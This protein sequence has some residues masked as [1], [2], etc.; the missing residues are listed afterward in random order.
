MSNR[1]D[2]LFV[3]SARRSQKA[4]TPAI[5]DSYAVARRRFKNGA[6][7]PAYGA[8]QNA[9][10]E[11]A[12]LAMAQPMLQ[13]VASNSQYAAANTAQGQNITFDLQNVGLNTKIIIEVSGTLAATAGQNLV[14][15][16]FG[17]LNFLSNVQ[18]TDLSNYQ[19]VNTTGRHLH[20]LACIRRQLAFGAAYQN[21]S[22][23][24][25]GST[26]NVQNAEQNIDEA[27]TTFRIFYE[28]P[29]AYGEF[30]L[31]GAIY[32]SVVNA[33]WRLQVTVNPSLTVATGGTD[34]LNPAYIS[35]GAGTGSLTNVTFKVYQQYLDQLPRGQNGVPIV[36]LQSLAYNYLIQT[37]TSPSVV[38]N[39]DFP[40]QYANFRTFLS[41]IAVYVNNGALN[42]GTDINYLGI[43][44]ANQT[45]LEKVDPFL[46]SLR[47]RNL[48]G[49]DPPKGT[50]IFDHRRKPIETQQ[51]GNM[52][53][54]VNAATATSA[55][56]EMMYEMLS[57]QSQAINAGSLAVT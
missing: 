1:N 40:I 35:T 25:L 43:Q 17:M 56:C 42:A 5:G 21:D 50:Y 36:P 47:A 9:A 18:L 55:Y 31:R 7:A 2:M 6:P 41:T 38:A 3:R 12:V 49:S 13:Q 37:T 4:G 51:Y 34:P 54:V 28:V 22:P 46:A 15:T 23:V 16:Q 20:M 29:L 10:A 33:T 19:R 52:Q 14:A 45:F 44:V 32:A 8:Q 53:F 11:Q 27:G 24:N 48:I 26:F 39:V 57:I 30:D